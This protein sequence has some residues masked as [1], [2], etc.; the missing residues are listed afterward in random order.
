MLNPSRFCSIFSWKPR[1]DGQ[2][3]TNIVYIMIFTYLILFSIFNSLYIDKLSRPDQP[4][5]YDIE[6]ITVNV[7]SCSFSISSYYERTPR[8]ICYLL[9]VFTV[10]IRNHK[11][12]AA[13]AATSVLTYSGVAAVHIIVLFATNNRLHLQKAKTHCESLSFLGASTPFVAC[14]GVYD[15]DVGL[16]MTIVGSVMLGALP[17]VA[18]STMFRRSTSKAILLQ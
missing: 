11:W 1:R 5:Y 7:V 2:T 13:G 8:Y 16:S 14:A 4:E 18:W 15:P 10:F 3:S 9:L 6:N 12:L 17:I